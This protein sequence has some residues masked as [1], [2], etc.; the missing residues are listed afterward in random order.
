MIIPS[1]GDKCNKL[2]FTFPIPSYDDYTIK[3]EHHIQQRLGQ[4]APSTLDGRR[5][6][7]WRCPF[8]Y[9]PWY[10]ADHSSFFVC[11]SDEQLTSIGQRLRADASLL[12]LLP[13]S[14]CPIC[15]A[16]HLGR[17]P[18]IEEDCNGR[19]YRFTWTGTKQPHLRVCCIIE[20]NI[21]SIKYSPN[22]QNSPFATFATPGDVVLSP[23]KQ[24]RSIL[25]CLTTLPEPE[26]EEAMSLSESTCD[27]L[28]RRDRL[29]P[30]LAWCGYSWIA[31]CSALGDVLVALGMTFPS[32]SV[33]S[34]SFLVACW[35]QVART[36]ER[37]L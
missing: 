18:G 22:V 4:R 23:L 8:C 2:S 6:I 32:S 26:R 21:S 24:V 7:L 34:L 3:V 5:E 30:G 37:V 28:N 31:Q 27:L 20:K 36:M 1:A 12:F 16:I 9:K 19:G 13:T 35:Q 14:I 33:C 11:L 17:M 15:A 29:E 10:Q 25:H